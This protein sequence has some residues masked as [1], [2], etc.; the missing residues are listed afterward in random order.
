MLLSNSIRVRLAAAVPLLALVALLSCKNDS[1]GPKPGS[2]TVSTTLPVDAVRLPDSVS[3][4]AM[5]DSGAFQLTIENDTT[6]HVQ[7]TLPQPLG[8]DTLTLSAWTLTLRTTVALFQADAEGTLHLLSSTRDSLSIR[9]LQAFDSLR[10]KSAAIWGSSTDSKSAQIASLEKAYATLLL[11]RDSAVSGFPAIHPFG[12]DSLAVVDQL[13]L[14]SALDGYTYHT[15]DSLVPLDSAKLLI[16]VRTLAVAGK[17]DS[18]AIFPP[19]PFVPNHA[20]T[21]AGALSISRTFDTTSQIIPNWITAISPGPANESSQKVHFE[22]VVDS[23]ASFFSVL[24]VVDSTGTLRYQ[25]KSTGKGVFRVRAHDNGDSTGTNVNV[26]GWTTFTIQLFSRP[27]LTITGIPDT[28]RL[29]EDSSTTLNILAQNILGSG[30]V[31][32]FTPADTTLIS[33]HT[34]ALVPDA[35]AKASFSLQA[36]TDVFGG[37]LL[38]VLKVS[39]SLDAISQGVYVVIAERNHPPTFGGATSLLVTATAATRT[40]RGWIDSISA[41]PASESSQKVSFQVQVVSGSSLFAKAPSVDSS[42]TLSFAGNANAS[43]LAQI[44]VRAVDNDSVDPGNRYS[45]WKT[46]SISFNQPP[47]L[48]LP[49]HT[50]STWENQ[51]IAVGAATVLDLETSANSLV[52]TWTVSDSTILPSDSILVP[53]SGGTR[54]IQMRPILHKWGS[55]LVTFSLAD[56]QGASTSDTLRLTVNPINH[57]PTL[58]MK[59]PTLLA[60]TWK[61]GQTFALASSMWDDATPSQTGHYDLQLANATDSVYISTLSVDSTGTLHVAAKLDTSASI[62]FRIRAHDNGGKANGGTDTSAWSSLQTLQLVDTVLDLDGN[63]YRARRMPD[64]NVWMRSNLYTKPRNGDT[65]YVCAGGN[66]WDSTGGH[67]TPDCPKRGALYSWGTAMGRGLDCDTSSTCWQNIPSPAQG[68][69]PAG[70]HVAEISEWSGLMAVTTTPGSTDSTYN[71][72]SATSDWGD[73]YTGWNSYP[74]AGLYGDFLVPAD[75]PQIC[76]DNTA[77]STNGVNLWLPHRQAS[78]TNPVPGGLTFTIQEKFQSHD[79]YCGGTNTVPGSIRCV[80]NPP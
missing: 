62:T 21:F 51:P 8:S 29:V 24:P 44:Q 5:G 28:L 1:T 57:A 47:T 3:W 67:L 58:T 37:P 22:V 15:L 30:L 42:G 65:A 38:G 45:A 32:T 16:Q 64:G 55:V 63:S 52:L 79:G 72:R 17:L 7:A 39:D 78:F 75:N 80:L 33:A 14:L 25:A 69:C 6:F 20:P 68:L 12:I 10:T 49:T 4:K 40:Y 46:T 31:A 43:G 76:G 54:N 71:L 56:S 41:G 9:L 35:S 73:H 36:K 53:S 13:L 19:P 26:S 11:A 77:G 60:T 18:N 70:W 50:A 59:S 23:G 61:G 66:L 74:G 27:V 48:T 2:A 34:F